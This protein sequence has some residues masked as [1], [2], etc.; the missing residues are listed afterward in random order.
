ME[1]WCI[2]VLTDSKL[3][4]L[5]G[6]VPFWIWDR[7][8]FGWHFLAA[9][10]W[11]NYNAV[12]WRSSRGTGF[13]GAVSWFCFFWES[14]QLCVAFHIDVVRVGKLGVVFDF[15]LVHWRRLLQ[16]YTVLLSEK[17]GGQLTHDRNDSLLTLWT[18]M[19]WWICLLRGA[20]PSIRLLLPPS[21]ILHL[22]YLQLRTLYFLSLCLFFNPWTRNINS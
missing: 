10:C 5:Y 2:F 18:E 1:G 4:S 9:D 20:M 8:D 7:T 13:C 21:S 16:H 6:S 19:H 17:K 15:F 11:F 22:S 3:A 14:H 12:G